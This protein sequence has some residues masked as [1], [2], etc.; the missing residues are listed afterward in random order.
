MALGR[1]VHH[2]I[3]TP[4]DVAHE[5]GVAD[6]AVHEGVA[7]RVGDVGEVREVA[8]IGELVE[9][10]HGVVGMRA[11]DMTNEVRPDE[12]RT[13]RHQNLHPRVISQTSGPT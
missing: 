8:R 9:I 12:P 11:Q 6:V 1:H 13:P 5:L 7:R 3:D 4:G 10:H 2:G